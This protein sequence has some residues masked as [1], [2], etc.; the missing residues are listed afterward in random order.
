MKS[1]PELPSPDGRY[2]GTSHR[3][4]I[5][6]VTNKLDLE[7]SREG[8]A[9]W[10]NLGEALSEL[11]VDISGIITMSRDGWKGSAAEAA[12][13]A[14][15]DLGKFSDAAGVQFTR[16]GEIISTQTEIVSEAA[17]R[18]PPLVEP[19]PDEI[20]SS[21]ANSGDIIKQMT[22]PLLYVAQKARADA[23]HAE[24]VNVMYARDNALYSA[25][26][27]MPALAEPPKVTQEHNTVDVDPKPSS[28]STGSVDSN[29]RIGNVGG[30]GTAVAAT[31]QVPGPTVVGGSD[32]TTRAS[33]TTP[34]TT[35]PPLTPPT[36]G[37]HQQPV[38][39]PGLPPAMMP[40]GRRPATGPV[41]P[42]RGVTPPG[43]GSPVGGG[44]GGRP[45]MPGGFPA[46]G[47]GGA[48]APGGPG[49]PGG[50]Q[51][52]GGFGPAGSGAFGSSGGQGRVAPGMAPVG[53]AAPAG[54][55]GAED[56]EHQ[57]KYLIPTDEY[58]DD[59]RMVAPETI[60][61]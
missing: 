29:E 34:S 16:T 40:P 8:A 45:G 6:T 43:G 28:V 33:W 9:R 53:A 57:T 5:E 32:G 61:E 42:P 55:A 31:T 14:L 1:R 20:Y 59:T 52:A 44:R 18:M 46:A 48:G 30:T 11:A 54:T 60:G 22:A 15:L 39:P 27:G 19:T 26:L 47:G 12:R 50:A 25:T 51:R 36:P 38:T 7:L 13:N 35:P 24:A 49:V 3:E 58:F 2:E 23:A 56:Q 17:R 37:Y 10:K 41:V 21:M 4:L